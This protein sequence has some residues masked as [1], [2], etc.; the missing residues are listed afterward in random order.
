MLA[1][2]RGV[3]GG[4]WRGLEEEGMG[5]VEGWGGG[6]ERASRLSLLTSSSVTNVAVT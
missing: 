1:C 2:G 5:G 4:G 6:G 3:V